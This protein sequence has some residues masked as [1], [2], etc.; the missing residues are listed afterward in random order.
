MWTRDWLSDWRRVNRPRHQTLLLFPI[1]EKTMKNT[2]KGVCEDNLGP[3]ILTTLFRV[4]VLILIVFKTL[5]FNIIKKI[6]FF[7]LNFQF[8]PQGFFFWKKK[9]KKFKKPWA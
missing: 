6:D 2:L 5:S 7:K 4:L 8:C 9:E 1:Q 3:A